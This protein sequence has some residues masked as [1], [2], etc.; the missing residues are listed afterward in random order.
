MGL[1]ILAGFYL[2]LAISE[3]DQQRGASECGCAHELPQSRVKSFWLYGLFAIPILL[4]FSLPDQVM[5]SDVVA[6]KGMNLNPNTSVNA[7]ASANVSTPDVVK[8]SPV[9]SGESTASTDPAPSPDSSRGSEAGQQTTG[10]STNELDKLFPAD[11][12]SQDLAKLGKRLYHKPS[13][14]VTTEGFLE[15]LTTL[16][17]YKDNFL[18]VNVEL[19]GFVYRDEGM[20]PSQFVVSRMVMQCCSADALPYGILVK[21]DKFGAALNKDTWVHVIGKLTLTTYNGTDTIQLEATTVDTIK[22]PDD[23]YVYPYFE[24]IDKLKVE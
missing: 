9:T 14:H 17:M 20:D 2:F 15:Y 8:T 12:F 24:D 6:V 22:A 11:E 16:D 1:F 5:G 7:S 10:D 21:S 18:G 13:I 19:S 3:S 23:P 4:G